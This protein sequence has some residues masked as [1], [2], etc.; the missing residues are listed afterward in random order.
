MAD[1]GGALGVLRGVWEV[2]PAVGE[3]M[4]VPASLLSR[5]S[6]TQT[7]SSLPYSRRYQMNP[8]R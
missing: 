6:G 1:A 3:L 2:F 4:W 7:A 5:C 8:T